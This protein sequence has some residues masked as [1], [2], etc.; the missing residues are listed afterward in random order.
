M[1]LGIKFSML[2]GRQN[3]FGTYSNIGLAIEMAIF[4]SLKK[5]ICVEFA[6]EV[7]LYA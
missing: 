1:D 5:L 2:R 7:T 3:I 4:Y 6:R